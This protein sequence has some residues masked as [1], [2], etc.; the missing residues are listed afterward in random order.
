LANQYLNAV[1]FVL[2][3]PDLAARPI[4]KTSI[5]NPEILQLDV[6]VDDVNGLKVMR[7]LLVNP[8]LFFMMP[9]DDIFASFELG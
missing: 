9:I 3:H 6:K 8:C 1:S 4:T 2:D 7:L 5:F